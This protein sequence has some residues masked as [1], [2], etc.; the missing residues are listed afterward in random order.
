MRIS[1]YSCE[2]D[3]E[4]SRCPGGYIQFS[5]RLFRNFLNNQEQYT[6]YTGYNTYTG[7][8]KREGDEFLDQ[9]TCKANGGIHAGVEDISRKYDSGYNGSHITLK[10]IS[11]ET[12]NISN[13]VS[14]VVSDG[15]WVSWVIF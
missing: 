10:K 3:S 13:V 6:E 15:C 2:D 4:N 11:S 9:F 1:E 8:N 7:K 14:D 5:M 12:G